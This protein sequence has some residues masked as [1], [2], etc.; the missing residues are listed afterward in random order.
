MTD[1]LHVLAGSKIYVVGGVSTDT[2]QVL[3]SVECYDTDTDQWDTSLPD[4]PIGAKSLACV[5][6]ATES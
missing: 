1:W 2:N 3:R 4:L 6:I 5:V